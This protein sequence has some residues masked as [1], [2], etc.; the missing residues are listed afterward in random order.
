MIRN[1]LEIKIIRKTENWKK[2]L[3][4]KRSFLLFSWKIQGINYNMPVILKLSD[5]LES[6]WKN[7]WIRKKIYKN[8]RE[9][10]EN[11][12]WERKSFWRI[13]FK[14]EEATQNGG[15]PKAQ[16]FKVSRKNAQSKLLHF[17]WYFDIFNRYNRIN[18]RCTACTKNINSFPM[19]HSLKIV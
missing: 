3:Q 4:G 7:S 16:Q 19:L 9:N 12:N 8:I 18:A 14:N 13:C 6:N 2:E 11:V 1:F 17:C 15:C 10:K 5:N